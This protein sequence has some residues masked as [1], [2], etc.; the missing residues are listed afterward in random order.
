MVGDARMNAMVPIA[1]GLLMAIVAA[2]FMR[3]TRPGQ[4]QDAT[5]ITAAIRA[6]DAATAE[7]VPALVIAITDRTR[8]LDRVSV[9]V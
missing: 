2:G 8:G 3:E 9:R 6:I 5:R 1:G 7:V 4:A